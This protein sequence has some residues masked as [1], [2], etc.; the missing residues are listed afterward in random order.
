M[1]GEPFE[2]QR[3]T[4]LA[5]SEAA[6]IGGGSGHPPAD[7]A[8]AP[9]GE[10]GGGEAEGFEQAEELLVEHASHGDS[11]SAH[12]ILHH[13]MPSEEDDGRADGEADG[14]RSSEADTDERS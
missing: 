9:V 1:P 5:A 14:E 13:Q 12:A 10:A 2:E 11:Q 7:P 3:E 4:E 6:R 8:E